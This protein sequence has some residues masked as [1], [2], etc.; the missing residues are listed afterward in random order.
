MAGKNGERVPTTLRMSP[1]DARL[2]GKLQKLRHETSDHAVV[3]S[4]FAKGL[5]H[6]LLAEGIRLYRDGLTLE[7]AAHT[8]GIPFGKLFA[9]SLAQS[10]TLIEDPNF[11][12][13][14]ADL[15][16]ALGIP[17]L[18]NAAERVLAENLQPA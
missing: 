4:A 2:V 13:H 7:E 18:T 14:T 11:L 8:V 6:E 10:V 1:A 15:G 5:Q 12:E 9:H 3:Y 17:A 16:R